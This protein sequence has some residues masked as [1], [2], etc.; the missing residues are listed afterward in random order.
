MPYFGDIGKAASDLLGGYQF[1]H[2]FS[3]AGKTAN[4]LSLT[5]NGKKKGEGVS[6]DLKAS[7]CPQKGITI[8]AGTDSSGKIDTTITLDEVC[9]G[10]KAA[11]SANMPCKDSGKLAF[12]YSGISGVGIKA[13][14]GLKMDPKIN[15]NA[16]YSYGS[17]II[18]TSLA[19]DVAKGSLSKYDVAAQYDGGDFVVGASACDALNTLKVSYLHKVAS[20]I[21]IAGECVH[22]TCAKSGK[23]DTSFAVGGLKKLDGGA[24]AKAH[25]TGAG[26]AS[27]FYSQELRPK[28]TGTVCTQ[29]DLKDF[30]KAAKFGLEIK[31]K[32]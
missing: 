28:T 8:D 6:G 4:G 1:D 32:A 31:T 16:A 23:V 17:A 25:M 10:L 5:T 29:F 26:I 14:T 12:T 13:D 3:V 2:K 15:A 21:S 9:A 20:D 24:S 7:Y 27:L 30:D 18:G 19:Y 11:L 22:K